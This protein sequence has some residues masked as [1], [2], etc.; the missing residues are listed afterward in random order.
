MFPVSLLPIP[1]D[2]GLLNI[3]KS[4]LFLNPSSLLLSALFILAF[5]SLKTLTAKLTFL[6]LSM[7]VSSVIMYIVYKKDKKE[8]IKQQQKKSFIEYVD[9]ENSA[10][11][12]EEKE[13]M[14]SKIFRK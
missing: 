8:T 4:F 3:F 12:T 2:A 1:L 11:Q 13:L 9:S 5:L 10:L 14:L 6:G 7:L